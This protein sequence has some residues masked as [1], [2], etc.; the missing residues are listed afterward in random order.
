MSGYKV[1]AAPVFQRT[2]CLVMVRVNRAREIPGYERI[3]GGAG[4]VSGAHLF[5][6][7]VTIHEYKEVCYDP[8]LDLSRASPEPLAFACFWCIPILWQPHDYRQCKMNLLPS[9]STPLLG[10]SCKA[11]V[12]CYTMERN[13][14]RDSL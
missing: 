8:G 7:L 1:K 14:W 3:T 5:F 10:G 6:I 13:L 4:T 2:C 11:G 12:A 9:H